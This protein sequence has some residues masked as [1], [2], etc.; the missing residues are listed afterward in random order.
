MT[1]TMQT[2]KATAATWFADQRDDILTAFEGLED[3]LTSG[4]T[5]DRTAGRFERSQTKRTADDGSD[6]AGSHG[7]LRR[8]T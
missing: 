2:E 4:P 8:G 6:A 1:N 3:E 7:P 5:A